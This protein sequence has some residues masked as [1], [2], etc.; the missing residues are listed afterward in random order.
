MKRSSWFGD[1]F[2]EEL[3]LEK[4]AVRLDRLNSGAPLLNNHNNGDLNDVIGVVENASMKQGQG[5]AMVRFSERAEIQGLVNDIKNGIIRNISVGY[6]VHKFEEL[7]E[8]ADDGLPIYRAVEWEP[9]ELSFVGIPADKGAQ[10]RGL[11]HLDHEAILETKEERNTMK[12]AKKEIAPSEVSVSDE[13]TRNAEVAATET[14]VESSEEAQTVA[15]E[16]SKEVS[17]A[18]ETVAPIVEGTTETEQRSTEVQTSVVDPEAIR[19]LEIERQADIRKAVRVAQLPENFADVLVSGKQTVEEARALIFKELEKRTSSTTF[20]QRVEVIDMEQ[21]DLR[22]EAATAAFLHRYDS[23]KYTMKQ[24]QGEF[25]GGS[26]IDSARHF[27]HLE[28]VKG[29]LSMSRT[30]IAKRALHSTSD[31]PSVLEN[32]TNKALRAGYEGA[33]STFAPFVQE[34]TVK[35]FKT[36][37][38]VQLSDGGTLD[39]VAESGEYTSTTLEE[40]KETYVVKKYGK[41]IGKTWELMVNDDLSAFTDIPSKLG[42]RAKEKENEIFWGIIIANAAMADAVTLFHASS[43]GGNLTS[44]GTAI[45]IT[46]LQVA[47]TVMRLQRDLDGEL[48]NL[49]PSYL[50]VPAAKESIAEQFISQNMLADASGNIN[51]FA[52]RLQLIVEP[53]LD[54]NSGVSWYMFADKGK[55]PMAELA[56]LEG[57][58][59]PQISVKEGFEVDGMQLKVRYPFGMKVVDYRG[60]Y[61]NA[62]A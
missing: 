38:S 40:S 18:Q 10:A 42:R 46:S 48:I 17:E 24:G 11:S 16:A 35:D 49:S 8:K 47:R 4:D 61:K 29:A 7:E 62:G 32:V 9:M 33:P 3:S 12:K 59:G 5:V 34:K 56:R 14:V 57:Y 41:I 58:A 45:S 6:R 23:S 37:S 53:R 30:E 50:V 22:I 52:G 2:H 55:V 43:H 25:A 19:T 60:F 28:G 1:E 26:L 20:N 31:F 15:T 36:I 21:R 13:A 51:P 27:L 39:E 54:A 44:S